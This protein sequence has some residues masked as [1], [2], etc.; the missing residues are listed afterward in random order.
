VSAVA[1]AAA[2]KEWDEFLLQVPGGS[3]VQTAAWAATKRA[4]GQQTQLTVAHDRNGQ[5]VGGASVVARRVGPGASVGYI[6]GGPVVLGDDTELLGLTLSAALRHI[7]RLRV[8]VLIVQL[9][10]GADERLAVLSRQGFVDGAPP[11]APEA[12]I[13]VDVSLGDD[14]LLAAMS[15]MRRRNIRKSWR[16]DIDVGESDDV[17]GFHRLHVATA[18]RQG[19]T[20]R[21]LEYLRAQWVVLRSEGQVAILVARHAGAAVAGLWLTRFGRT[22]T[23]R[24]PGWDVR[25]P[26]P[27]HVNEALHWGAIRWARAVGASV[28]DLGGFDRDSAVRLLC[29]APLDEGFPRTHGF[30]KLGF[31]GTP[32]LL[33]QA[34]FLVTNR[35]LRPLARVVGPRLL[36][37]TPA[38]R[39]ASAARNG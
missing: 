9:P 18:E 6:A 28:Y 32:V 33:P 25:L 24:L 35:A 19:F 21:S 34:Q 27:K 37:S 8:R 20:P 36:T 2:A 23:F 12:T 5:L 29:G 15:S 7:R 10:E 17:E 14:A 16:E 11:V 31:N 22:V 26:A 13:R 30:F 3:L 1:T 38:H 39:L 4:L